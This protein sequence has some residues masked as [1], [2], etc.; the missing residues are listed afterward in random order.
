MEVDLCDL[1]YVS[2]AARAMAFGG[3]GELAK[4]VRLKNLVSGITGLLIFDG[5]RFC[6]FLEGRSDQVVALFERIQVDPR[7][8]QVHFVH[9]GP[10]A[11][12]HFRRFSMGFAQTDDADMLRSFAVV[13]SEVAMDRFWGLVPA[14]DMEP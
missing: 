2:V 1:M 9:G 4:E 3:V 7:H 13:P 6:Q 14:L 5:E 8:D 10:S 12:R 11:Q